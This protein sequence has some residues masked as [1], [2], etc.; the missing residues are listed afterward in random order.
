MTEKRNQIKLL[1]FQTGEALNFITAA[2]E[3]LA[4]TNNL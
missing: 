2:K 1:R 3:L 4:F